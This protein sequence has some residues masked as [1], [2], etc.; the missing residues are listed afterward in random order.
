MYIVT[1][2]P[3]SKQARTDVLSYFT[4][5]ELA[6]GTVVIVPFRKK[7]MR[8][9]VMECVLLEQMKS[10]IKDANYKLR[11][12]SKVLPE[13][14]VPSEVIQAAQAC[15][16]YYLCPLSTILDDV[17]PTILFD[18]K[19]KH[20]K[21]E[22][23]VITTHTSPI[24]EENL[25]LGA[26]ITE[27]IAWYRTRI[28]ELFA[29]KHSLYIVLPTYTDILALKESLTRGIEEHSI[30]IS[31]T[32]TPK[33]LRATIEQIENTLHPICVFMTPQFVSIPRND[34]KT[35]IVE[36]D[37]ARGY[38]RI[39]HPYLD[40]RLFIE[41]FA[42]KAGYQ[43]IIGD[44]LLRV[45]T[46]AKIETTHYSEAFPLQLQ[47]AETLQEQIIP[48]QE[49]DKRIG[50]KILDEV[51]REKIHTNF[52]NGTHFFLFTL[53]NGLATMTTCRDCGDLL[54]C[55]YCHAP[56]VLY[57]NK[58]KRIFICNVCKRHTPSDSKCKK[59]GS[60][61]LFAHGIGI[62]TVIKE[63]EETFPDYPIFRLDK[64]TISGD[65]E[66]KKVVERFYTT[67][68]STLI[69]TELAFGYLNRV[70]EHSAIVSFDSLF[71]IPS[72][73][74]GERIVQ[75][76]TTLRNLTTHSLSIQTVHPD[77]DL[78]HITTKLKL[79]TWYRQELEDRTTYNYPPT[80]TLI[81][82]SAHIEKN[83]IA[84]VKTYI[85]QS[86]I[87]W[88]P[89]IFITPSSESLRKEKVVCLLRVRE[90]KW[91]LRGIR[92]QK[93]KDTLQSLPLG[94]R[95]DVNPDNLI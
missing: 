54:T 1:V 44:T 65:K 91:S 83:Q 17:I 3:L 13:V 43:H 4:S 55:E 28:R 49:P 62:D 5:F 25:I 21:R 56:L 34:L 59:C 30:V 35:I 81:K 70:V 27:R 8:A 7:T 76:V 45:E 82:V 36:H 95:I 93:L 75:L 60:W 58:D 79:I 78:L 69:G 66:A 57:P 46:Y 64:N 32:F 51:L 23:G 85:E 16:E 94:F 39:T 77:D 38:E 20:V 15:S 12:I 24:Q 6:Q 72:F 37:S 29:Q 86:L 19:I 52:K 74:V 80:Y 73:R 63:F 48:R 33:T 40:M 22:G 14:F 90:E 92:D 10:Q 71:A 53:R 9:L 2:L 68:G 50:F 61:N 26:P 87:N 41:T 89:D 42:R 31:S 84:S 67:T 47:I 11:K 88:Q 18:E